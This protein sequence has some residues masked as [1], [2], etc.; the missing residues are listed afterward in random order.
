MNQISQKSQLA[1]TANTVCHHCGDSYNGAFVWMDE[2]P[3]CCEGCKMVYS[4][5]NENDLCNYYDLNTKAGISQKNQSRQAYA[6]LEDKEVI[7]KL[8]DFT[9]G[10]KT[11][12]RFYLPQIHCSA[13]LWLLE[14]LHRLNEGV[15]YSRVDFLKKEVRIT[16]SESSISLR[17]LVE[18]LASIGYAPEINLHDLEVKQKTLADKSLYYKL[19]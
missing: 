14:H 1:R 5:L 2:K 17:S 11:K 16:F 7:A 10:K 4:I 19:V 8:I 18:L 6:F 9:D 13:C 12:I 3:F 15:L